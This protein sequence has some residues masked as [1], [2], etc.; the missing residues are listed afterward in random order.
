M[1]SPRASRI[2]VA[3]LGATGAVG[4]RMVS[5]V[6]DHPWFELAELAASSRS[7][8]K[9]YG[10]AAAWRLAAPL[11]PAAGRIRVRSLGEEEGPFRSRLLLSALDAEIAGETEERL[12]SEG[13]AVV[14]NA[15]SHRL[16]P[17][18]P[19]VIPE[20]N[21]EHLRLLEAQRRRRGGKGFIVTNPNCSA[22]GLTMALAAIQERFGIESLVVATLQA[23]SGAGYPGLPSLDILD[24]AIPFIPGEEEKIERE[25]RKMLG[26]LSAA[27]DSVLEAGFPIA[28][29]VHRVPVV[30]GH[31]VSV[32]ARTRDD[33]PADAVLRAW[34]E[35]NRARALSTPTAPADPLVYLPGADR[36]QSRLDRDL[37]GGMSTAIGRLRPAPGGGF[38]FT[39]LAHNTLRGA[40]GA[41]LLNAEILAEQ[42]WLD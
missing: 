6:A 17:D 15:K 26:S 13:H 4:Q 19:L 9:P 28:A 39:C 24:N 14:S 42:G 32:L 25:P 10:E 20:V 40:A 7:A 38:Q 30:D 23:V 27:Q 1:A 41:A 16:D 36:P 34:S 5:L 2:P 3:V 37:G 8:G 35:W 31:L 18:V 29:M 22:T 33:A 11:P 12:A 21:H